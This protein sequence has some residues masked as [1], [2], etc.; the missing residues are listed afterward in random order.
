MAMCGNI[1]PLSPKVYEPPEFDP[2]LED[3][4]EVDIDD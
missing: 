1:K 3:A 2:D 4:E